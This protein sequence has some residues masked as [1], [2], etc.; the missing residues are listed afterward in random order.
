MSLKNELSKFWD[1]A[2]ITFAEYCEGATPPKARQAEWEGEYP[3]WNKLEDETKILI[4]MEGDCND[5]SEMQLLL[6]VLALDNES[7]SVKEWILD[8]VRDE[9]LICRIGKAGLESNSGHSR[10]LSIDLV[11][12]CPAEERQAILRRVWES[13]K[14]S[15]VKRRALLVLF[16]LDDPMNEKNA[17]EALSSNDEYIRLV[18]HRYL[19]KIGKGGEFFKLAL[20]D[21]SELIRKDAI[22]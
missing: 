4:Q 3:N 18:A 5:S 8:E 21:P 17:I 16:E 11:R 14:D 7:E 12:R 22:E 9:D 6:Q 13:E 15:Y 20:E 1:W 19:R 10:W 2:G